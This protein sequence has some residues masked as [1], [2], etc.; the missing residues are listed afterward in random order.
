LITT[1]A[2][3]GLT[4]DKGKSVFDEARERSPE[5]EVGKHL[6]A[7]STTMKLYIIKRE[8]K[9]Q[10]VKQT[11]QVIIDKKRQKILN[12]PHTL[13]QEDF[14]LMARQRTLINK[15]P[16]MRYTAP[17]TKKL[18]TRREGNINELMAG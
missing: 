5:L 15:T 14:Q 1:T 17:P 10:T 12:G 9:W 2:A 18:G 6:N 13:A 8:S 16:A 4:A 7:L 11:S 3:R